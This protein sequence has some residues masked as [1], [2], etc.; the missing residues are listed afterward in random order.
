MNLG[1]E[2]HLVG[3]K[4]DAWAR[5]GCFSDRVVRLGGS[6]LV[7]PMPGCHATRRD[8]L[9]RDRVTLMSFL[10]HHLAQV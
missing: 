6:Q 9:P 7:N 3:M 2:S 1:L 4:V 10:A 8:L 5:R